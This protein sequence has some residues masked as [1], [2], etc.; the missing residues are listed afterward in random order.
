LEASFSGL[1]LLALAIRLWELDGRVIHYDESI[2][3]YY[4]WRLSNLEEY[5]HAPWMHGPF[6][7]EFTALVF[8]LFSDTDF[9]A[10]LGYVIFGTALVGLPYF[11]RDYLGRLGALLAGM[12][13]AVSPALLY[14]SR[15]GREDIIMAFWSTALL[16]LVWRY[17]HEGRDRY[18]YL[19][20]A[21]LAFTF[22]TKETAYFVVLIFGALMFLLALPDLV[23][24][25]SGRTRLSQLAS[26]LPIPS[27]TPDARS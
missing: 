9:T 3:V 2:H 12:M 21:V 7:I 19:A 13:L 16:V 20:S 11:L 6:Q 22:A 4:A 24:L 17:I 10:R 14:F 23:P 15:F 1:V 18:L 26:G 27:M 5:I 8:R 25:V